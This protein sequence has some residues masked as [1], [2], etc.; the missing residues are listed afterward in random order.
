MKAVIIED[1]VV[2][3]QSLQALLA[4]AEPELQVVAVLQSIDEAVEWFQTT[5]APDVAFL[6]IHLADGSAFAIFEKIAVPCPVIFTTAY[7]EYALK[8][9]EVNSIDYLLKPIA[10]ADLQRALGKFKNYRFNPEGY[11]EVISKLLAEMRQSRAAYKSCFLV[12]KKD[13][14]L[15]LSVRDI[16]YIC[17]EA[18]IVRAFTYDGQA[19]CLDKTLDELMLQLDP[20]VFFRANR[21]FIVAR[22]ALKDMSVWFGGKLSVNLCVPVEERIIV[23]K[24][25][26][27]EFRRWVEVS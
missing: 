5:A 20:S 11:N 17:I 8:A 19:F 1:E 25:K 2:A 26:V 9:F 15:P 10:K 7:D 21:Q 13:K 23:S 18:Q 24:A 6:D 4:E 27:G 22:K 14:L 3:A 16:A 12:Q